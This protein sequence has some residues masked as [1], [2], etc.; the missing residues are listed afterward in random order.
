MVITRD[1]TSTMPFGL[2][3]RST[4]TDGNTTLWD[5]GVFEQTI[6]LHARVF[7][8]TDG[9]QDA[10]RDGGTEDVAPPPLL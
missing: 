4:S 5:V 9:G 6:T 2:S 10:D 8:D 1:T 7:A 3:L